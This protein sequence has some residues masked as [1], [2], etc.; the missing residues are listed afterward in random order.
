MCLVKSTLLE[1]KM[2]QGLFDN[3]VKDLA[4]CQASRS[5]SI[6]RGFY[7]CSASQSSEANQS[8]CSTCPHTK[9]Y[10]AALQSTSKSA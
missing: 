8:R 10:S 3:N 9:T 4:A 6:Q 5:G 1:K 7:Q 2:T